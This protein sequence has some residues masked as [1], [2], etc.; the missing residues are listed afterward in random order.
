MLI[1]IGFDGLLVCLSLFPV[2]L[3]FF[4]LYPGLIVKVKITQDSVYLVRLTH[5]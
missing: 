3:V 5:C 4:C 1:Y 2:F